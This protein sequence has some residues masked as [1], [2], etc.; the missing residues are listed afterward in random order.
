MSAFLSELGRR[1]AEKWL[2]ALVLPGLLFT[3]AVLLAAT[4]RH[5]HALDVD[6]LLSRA[7]SYN[8]D[9]RGTGSTAVLL[10][11]SG[12]LL[13]AAGA[14]L[15]AQAVAVPVRVVWLGRWPS[16]LGPLSSALV[17]RRA[18]RWQ[19][20]Q[21]RYAEEVERPRP[22]RAVIDALAARRNRI[23][24][25][26]PCRPTWIGDRIAATDRRVHLEYGLDLTS[27]WPR[28]W[29]TVPEEVRA[30]LRAAR[31]ALDSATTTAAWGVLYVLLGLLWWPAAVAG[32]G[33]LTAAWRRGR[34][35]AGELAELA[36]STVDL[37]GAALG[38]ALGLG[39]ADA[40]L[41]RE[42]GRRITARLR[43]GA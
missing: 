10:A 7:A 11:V 13:A 43:K 22:D 30:E 15:L 18:D 9:V 4:L 21:A 31:S 29:L 12:A 42:L 41:T 1:L 8:R 39:T 17:R 6:F 38:A 36:E 27:A 24:P 26:P 2:T 32:A 14:G 33:T 16:P 37:H 23:A 19:R 3:G 5:T 20:L 35:G 28:L 34:S 25:A 40:P